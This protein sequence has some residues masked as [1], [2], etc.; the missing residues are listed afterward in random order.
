MTAHLFGG[1]AP[2]LEAELSVALSVFDL[3]VGECDDMV[4]EALG[5]V[6]VHE[7][8]LSSLGQARGLSTHHGETHAQVLAAH[9]RVPVVSHPVECALHT[10]LRQLQAMFV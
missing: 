3:A 6:I 4:S 1:E 5:V 8:D 9:T 2:G 7:M 10:Q